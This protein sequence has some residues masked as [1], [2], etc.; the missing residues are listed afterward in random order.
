L[1]L[2]QPRQRSAYILQYL[3]FT[4][5]GVIAHKNESVIFHAGDGVIVADDWVK[6]LDENNHPN[7]LAYHLLQPD[8]KAKLQLPPTF[9]Q[10]RV[11]A[12]WQRIAIGTDGFEL[13]LLPQ[14]WGNPHQRGLQRKMNSWSNQLHH[15]KD[16]ATIVVLEK[17]DGND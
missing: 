9:T 12:R 2:A 10:E 4:V 14:V 3:L 5:I 16:D 11:H 7:Y 8:E 1:T 13:G 17:D 15:F 6:K